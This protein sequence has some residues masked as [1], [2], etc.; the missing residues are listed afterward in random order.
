MEPRKAWEA[1]IAFL[2]SLTRRYYESNSP[3]LP[4]DFP[5]R[6]FAAQLWGSK[7]YVRH[8]SFTR[9]SDVQSFLARKAPRHFYYS[10]A[11]Y[12]QPGVDDMDAKGW[13]SADITFDIDADHLAECRDS[14]YTLESPFEGKTSLV[15]D[16]CLKPAARQAR[17][18]VDILVEELGFEQRRISVEFSGNR[19]FHVTVLLPDG[20]ERARSGSEYRR[21]L[22]NYIKAL[23]LSVET[24][25]PWRTLGRKSTLQPVP[26]QAW[27]AGLR[28][29]VARIAARLAGARDP[30]LAKVFLRADP[31]AAAA[32]YEERRGDIDEVLAKAMEL[33]GVEVDEQVTVDTRRLVRA[34]LSVNGK[35]GLVVKPVK[36]EE[37]EGFELG[38]ELS[39][40]QGEPA[41]VRLV[42]DLPRIR[43]IGYT[44]R[45]RAGETPRLPLPLAGYLMAR[46]LAVLAR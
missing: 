26:P 5:L 37:L 43:V 2:R 46:G 17:L 44:L 30:A 18:L 4:S 29:R 32:L 36:P 40:F 7:S 8:M 38:E 12:E 23:G 9:R 19:G 34:P 11:R 10:S 45:L 24:I 28:G 15:P 39:A 22:V 31:L 42:A 27:M 20:D 6:E 41:R 1:S 13:R 21:E 35:T 14:V 16:D 3:L 25:E 33:V